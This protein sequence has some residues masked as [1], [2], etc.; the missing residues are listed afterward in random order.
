MCVCVDTHTY[1]KELIYFIRP[2]ASFTAKINSTESK[3]SM[4]LHRIV[5]VFVKQFHFTDLT[6][7]KI[8]DFWVIVVTNCVSIL[9][10]KCV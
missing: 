6:L 1:S 9:L 3:I 2:L 5:Q 7:G 10:I 8:D 4:I